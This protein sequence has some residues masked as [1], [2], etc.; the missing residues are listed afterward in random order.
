MNNT[1]FENLVLLYIWGRE[2]PFSA[3]KC[4]KLYENWIT[5]LGQ[6]PIQMV[7]IHTWFIILN[8]TTIMEMDKIMF[9]LSFSCP[10]KREINKFSS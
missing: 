1:M 9:R 3:T 7:G 4:P 5:E 6:R 10:V 8:S 2:N